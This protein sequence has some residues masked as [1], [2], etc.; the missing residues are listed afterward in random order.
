MTVTVAA[1][2][3][4][5]PDVVA[6]ATSTYSVSLATRPTA[7][8]TVTPASGDT[9][10]ATVSGALTFTVSDWAVAQNVTVSGVAAGSATVTHS[11]AGGD[12][13]AVGADSVTVTVAARGVIVDP[14]TLDVVAGA[15]STYTIVLATRPTASVTVTPASG[16][17]N[18]ATVSGALTFT[19]SDWAVAQTVTVSGAAAGSATVT[20]SVAGGDYGA[21]G[22]DSVTV[23]VAARGVIVDPQT[24]D[25]VAGA[26]STYTIV[27]ATRPTASVTVTPASGDTATATVSGALTFTVSDWAT[28]QTVTVSGAAA[29]SVSV[30]H[31][32]SGGDY[33]SN[34]VTAD[35]VAV[36]VAARGVVVDPAALDVIVGATNT[37]EVSL[38]T[39][40]TASVTVTPASGDT[41]TATVSGALTFTV[42]DWAT[43]QTVTVSG[44]AAGSVSVSHAVS[45]GDYGANNVAAD[46]VT[47]TVAARGVIVDPQ[48][49]DVVAGA[50][51]TYTVVLATEPDCFGDGDAGERGHEHGDGVGRV[52]VHDRRIGRSRRM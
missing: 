20:H 31:A 12:Y 47:V 52:D 21:V 9:A 43:A 34:N 7:S 16:D 46:S 40:P 2:G 26:T 37:Y 22:A 15:T 27:L 10:T 38:A 35:S 4:I 24:L 44:V 45:G 18:T 49:L 28:A 5:D 14:Q 33:G 32:V 6:G 36:T 51:S 3:V 30:S 1:R 29:G 19:V 8:V 50:T 17:T 25:V 23:T 11:V 39:E 48:T 13:G 41:A 42:S